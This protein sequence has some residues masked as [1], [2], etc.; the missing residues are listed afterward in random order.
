LF[1]FRYKNCGIDG[2]KIKDIAV[3]KSFP[4]LVDMTGLD[5]ADDNSKS[6]E[7]LL[8]MIVMGRIPDQTSIPALIDVQ[9]TKGSWSLRK[10]FPFSMNSRKIHKILFVLSADEPIPQGLIQCVK[11]VA[12]PDGSAQNLNPRCEYYHEGKRFYIFITKEHLLINNLKLRNSVGI[13]FL[14]LTSQ[15]YQFI[16]SPESAKFSIWKFLIYLL[17]SFDPKI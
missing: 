7:E 14:P 13:V 17:T 6:L 10:N 2:A 12:Q 9:K 16:L 3:P 1:S 15:H 4:D 5:I 11:K 8:E